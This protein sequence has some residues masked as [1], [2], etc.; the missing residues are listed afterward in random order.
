MQ[1]EDRKI[2]LKILVGKIQKQVYGNIQS[3][4]RSSQIQR[5]TSKKSEGVRSRCLRNKMKGQSERAAAGLLACW[6]ACENDRKRG[7]GFT[8]PPYLKVENPAGIMYVWDTNN[9]T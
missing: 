1:K 2:H 9:H 6:L 3:A 4:S 8:T 5:L 7:G